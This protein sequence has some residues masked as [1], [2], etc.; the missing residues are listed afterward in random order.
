MPGGPPPGNRTPGSAVN[1]RIPIRGSAPLLAVRTPGQRLCGDVASNRLSVASV[2]VGFAQANG[3]SIENQ[4]GSVWEVIFGYEDQSLLRRTTSYHINT[5]GPSG[6]SVSNRTVRHQ[7]VL[8]T[9]PNFPSPWADCFGDAEG[10]AL[11]INARHVSAGQLSPI[12]DYRRSCARCG[13]CWNPV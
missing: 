13:D 2:S 1:W 9:L 5:S 7:A 6:G 10:T 8:C 12:G 4:V 11:R 3:I